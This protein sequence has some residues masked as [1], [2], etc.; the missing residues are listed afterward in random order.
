LQRRNGREPV[1]EAEGD[2]GRILSLMEL[3]PVSVTARE[4]L[5]SITKH[6]GTGEVL[7]GEICV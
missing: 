3:E 6:Y 4:A 5:L 2:G 1:I 7:P